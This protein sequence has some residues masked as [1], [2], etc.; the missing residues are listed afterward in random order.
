MARFLFSAFADEASKDILEQIAACKENGI[1]HIELRGVGG[2]N[3]SDFSVE[4]AEELKK[5]LDANGIGVSSI[6]SHYGKICIDDD[7][8]P[9]FESFK[10]TVE[11]ADILETEFIRIFSFYIDEDEKPE[12]YRDEVLARVGAMAKYAKSKGITCCHENERGIY[13]NVPER[14]LDMLSELK[15]FLG[16][17]FDPANFIMDGVD[18]LAAYEM[19]EPY[20]D[21]MHIKDALAED[22]I[23][24]PAG[25]GD[26]HI[27]EILRRFARK[28][29]P[30]FLSVE[31]HLKVFDGLKALEKTGD[32]AEKMR[33]FSYPSNRESFAAACSALHKLV[34]KVQPVRYGIIGIG[35]MGSSHLRYYLE[36]SLAEMRV[37]AV[38]DI[39]PERLEWAKEQLPSVLCYPTAEAMMDSGEVDAVV[40][41]TPHYF[42]PIYTMYALEKGLHAL[43]EKPAGV[44]TKKVR[45]A[46]EAAAKSDKVYAIMYNQRT[47]CL[48]R[49][50]RELVQGGEF[51][52][53]KR[54]NW[55]ITNWYRT[56]AYYNSGGW[57]ATWEGEGGGVLLNQCP[58]NLDLW[59]WICGMPS[60]ILAF[61]HEGKWHDI[62]VEDDVTIYA[63]YPNGA[64]GVFITSTGDAPGTNR[65]EITMDKGHIV[66]ED[67][68]LKVYTLDVS[69]SEHCMNSPNGFGKPK[70][71]WS[72]AETDGENP[73]HTGVL[74]AFAAN[75]LRGEP[76]VG[77]GE[78]GI[79]GLMISNAAHLS[80]WLGKPVDLPIDEDLFYEK[81]QE[82]IAGSQSKKTDTGAVAQNM[83]D[84]FGN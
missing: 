6:G 8:E 68:K 29:G 39:N 9:H 15:G 48:Y 2:K 78:E 11:V 60:K 73:Q 83:S 28:D 81:L 16:G 71:Q 36:G 62:E 20:I 33:R 12:D 65:L 13:G 1:T 18:T 5:I 43:T 32:V 35:N 7:F 84:S 46:N 82:K 41:A 72:E 52:E 75:I 21:Y 76:L 10:N 80:S 50:L 67:G 31:P 47:N 54:V 3:I 42:H 44:Y 53:I 45:E 57:R 30:R 77:R 25:E 59:Q 40:I 66:C 26:G 17:I 69:T 79:N 37:T 74:N 19:L 24:V 56:Q 23:I 22:R 63:E 55:I 61:C 34:E 70:G 64:T 58:H 14:C 38:A 4:E 27:E 49:K 51:G